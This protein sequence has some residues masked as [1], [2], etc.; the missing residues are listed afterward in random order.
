MSSF[1]TSCLATVLAVTT[2][3][4]CMTPQRRGPASTLN[5]SQLTIL[6]Q[7]LAHQ[8]A[9]I[10]ESR[11][12]VL[13]LQELFDKAERT[14]RGYELVIGSGVASSALGLMGV[15]GAVLKKSAEN[16]SKVTLVIGSAMI[17]TGIL[18]AI[19]GKHHLEI[20]DEQLKQA[21]EHLAVE[22]TNLDEHLR[23]I[24]ELKEML[25]TTNPTI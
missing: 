9:E 14:S 11:E 20:S 2:L 16:P 21:K 3:S 8:E 18:T 24:I 19:Y 17:G 6:K 12:K 25:G 1:K 5:E 23:S 4:A 15:A 10:K 7:S 22:K 13:A